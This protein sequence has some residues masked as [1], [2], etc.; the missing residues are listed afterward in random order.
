MS[1]KAKITGEAANGP[2]TPEADEHLYK[3][4][5]PFVPDTYL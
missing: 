2:C 4:K 3:K 1:T 5:Y